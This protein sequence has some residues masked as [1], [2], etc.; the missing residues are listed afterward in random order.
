MKKFTLFPEK[1]SFLIQGK[2]SFHKLLLL[3]FLFSF[4]WIIVSC[5]SCNNPHYIIPEQNVNTPTSVIITGPQT[6]TPGKYT[7]TV[8]VTLPERISK[9]VAFIVTCDIYE[10]DYLGDVVLARNVRLR[11]PVNATTASATFELEIVDDGTGNITIKGTDGS[12]VLEDQW[13]IYGYVHEQTTA[14]KK[15]GDNLGVTY[16]NP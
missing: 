13:H 6:V 14:N 5:D 3:T 9:D 4:I 1:R 7:Y 16:S 12:D 8:T 15:S 2:P 10:D 11:F